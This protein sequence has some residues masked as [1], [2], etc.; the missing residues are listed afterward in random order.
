[1]RRHRYLLVGSANEDEARGL[2]DRLQGEAPEG[3]KIHVEPGG[4]MVW[5]VTP[6]NPF[7]VFGGLGV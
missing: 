6:R 4:Q 5:E 3:A 1:M 2:A 7:V